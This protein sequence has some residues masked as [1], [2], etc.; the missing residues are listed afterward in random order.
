M[1]EENNEKTT[2]SVSLWNRVLET[3][4]RLPFVKV[5]RE[6]FLTKELTKFCTPME[7][8]TALDDTPLKVLS[9]KEIVK[10]ILN[11]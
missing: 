6:E 7:V 1:S 5:D 10:K 8:M 2:Q 11:I 3:S 9:K 4:L